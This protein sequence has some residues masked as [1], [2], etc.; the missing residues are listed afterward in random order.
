MEQSVI[1]G[2]VVFSAG[3]TIGSV[4]LLSED[5]FVPA[6]EDDKQLIS[7]AAAFL[8]SMLESQHGRSC[9]IVVEN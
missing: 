7:S 4:M 2:A 8:S 9:I 1:T 3:C 6:G 5:K